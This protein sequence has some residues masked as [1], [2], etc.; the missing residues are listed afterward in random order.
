[1]AVRPALEKLYQSLNDEQK[2]RLNALG[3]DELDQQQAQSNLAQVCNER[4]SGVAN[5]PID[6]I[7]RIVWPDEAQHGVLQELQDATAQAVN[8]LQAD[9]PTVQPLTMP[10]RLQ[11]MEQRL[12]AMLRAI[13]LTQPALQRFYDT[14]GHEQVERFNRLSPGRG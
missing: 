10:G 9:C 8:L 7:E 6:R 12:D 1:R 5:L 14:L 13:E 11:A 2:A 4:A 3:P